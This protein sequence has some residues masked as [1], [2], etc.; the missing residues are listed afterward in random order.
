MTVGD[1]SVALIGK[2]GSGKDT[3]AETLIKSYGY[4]RYAFADNLK[5]LAET[6]FPD[7][8]NSKNKPRQ[9]LQD[10]GMAFRSIDEDVWIRTMLDDIQQQYNESIAS[11][12]YPESIVVTDTR[13]PNEYQALKD[14]GFKFIRVTV[15]EDI[16]KQRMINRGDVFNSNN[17]KH[18]TESYYDT[19]EC[20]Y[21]IDNNGTLENM[22]EQLKIIVN[23][24]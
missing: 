2:M 14:K 8:Y 21:M 12:Y 5:L 3:V 13:L 9:L 1:M 22:E 15:D 4:T 6:W 20:D 24:F 11:L 7:Q 18:T 10:L 17:M 23:S 19:F 16:C